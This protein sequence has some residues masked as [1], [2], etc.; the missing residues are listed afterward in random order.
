ML[1]IGCNGRHVIWSLTNVTRASENYVKTKWLTLMC[2]VFYG[3]TVTLGTD[4]SVR[5]SLMS[6][7][8]IVTLGNGEM[9]QI[10]NDK[11]GILT[12]RDEQPDKIKDYGNFGL[13]MGQLL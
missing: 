11:G 9:M 13:N 7:S 2:G 4:F 10:P 5:T 3:K 6:N 12:T 1:N 8:Y